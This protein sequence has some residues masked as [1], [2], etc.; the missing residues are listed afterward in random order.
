MFLS[1]HGSGAT[2][3]LPCKGAVNYVFIGLN[4]C[5]TCSIVHRGMSYG[6]ICSSRLF[7]FTAYTTIT[8]NKQTSLTWKPMP[9]S[10]LWYF[11]MGVCMFARTTGKDALA[12]KVTFS[13][14]PRFLP[15]L[16]ERTWNPS[17]GTTMVIDSFFF[18]VA[19][20]RQDSPGTQV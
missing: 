9:H 8:P 6:G 19:G 1:H 3:Y 13:G 17:P 18:L 11:L 15:A 4:R 10:L 16:H 20:C 7:R 12:V 2:E 5:Y 14:F